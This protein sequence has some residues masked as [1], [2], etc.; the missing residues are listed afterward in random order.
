MN[1]VALAYEGLVAFSHASGGP[2][3]ARL[4][5]ALAVSVPEPA[6]DGRRYVFRLRSGLRYSDGT[7]VRAADVRASIERMLVVLK[8]GYPAPMFDAIVGAPRCIETRRGATC[9][10]VSPP[11]T[12]PAP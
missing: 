4:V 10:A 2:A 6:G 7:P 3:G 11:T 12:G 9:R 8:G 5:P 1:I